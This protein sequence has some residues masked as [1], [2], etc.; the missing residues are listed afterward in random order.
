MIGAA[1]KGQFGV[2][3]RSEVNERLG[4]PGSYKGDVLADHNLR[5][6]VG[7]IFNNFSSTSVAGSIVQR[8][9]KREIASLGSLGRRSYKASLLSVTE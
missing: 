3:T 5:D 9:H 7:L 2:Q 4:G 8:R 6:K 1:Q